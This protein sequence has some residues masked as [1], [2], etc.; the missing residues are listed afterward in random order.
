MVSNIAI[1]CNYLV[2]N[3]TDFYDQVA[4]AVE[5]VLHATL[6]T[7][8]S[9]QPWPRQ[10]H[11]AFTVT[12]VNRIV[13]GFSISDTGRQMLPRTKAR[14]IVDGIRALPKYR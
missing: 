9:L 6:A 3:Y 4:F 1:C 8:P 2:I 11:S 13:S 5:S 10:V 7:D 14:L 12:C